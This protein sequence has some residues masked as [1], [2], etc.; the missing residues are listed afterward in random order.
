MRQ[1]KIHILM[2]FADK[3]LANQVREVDCDKAIGEAQR[4]GQEG[5]W[6]D[7]MGWMVFYPSH[8]INQISIVSKDL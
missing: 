2:D 4:I 1:V 7:R 6:I 8:R 3:A 5:I